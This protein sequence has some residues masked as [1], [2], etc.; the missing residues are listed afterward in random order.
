MNLILIFLISRGERILDSQHM[1]AWGVSQTNV[2]SPKIGN[3]EEI[4]SNHRN[5]SKFDENRWKSRKSIIRDFRKID[6]LWYKITK[7]CGSFAE[8]CLM[9]I[10]NT[11]KHHTMVSVLLITVSGFHAKKSSFRDI[12]FIEFRE[13]RWKSPKIDEN[14]W[15]KFWNH[16]LSRKVIVVDIV[17]DSCKPACSPEAGSF[18]SN[19]G[20]TPIFRLDSRP[21]IRSPGPEGQL[22]LHYL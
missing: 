8:F 21:G 13:N 19:S 12:I 5:S 4:S 15:S 16:D 2:G 9:N 1:I 17:H 20:N 3:V 10:R 18:R 22:W 11:C 14:R 7:K 6:Y